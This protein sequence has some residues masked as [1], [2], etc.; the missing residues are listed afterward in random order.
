M[1]AKRLFKALKSLLKAL[2]IRSIGN[3]KFSFDMS[4]FHRYWHDIVD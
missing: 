1:A 2:K 3:E 4:S